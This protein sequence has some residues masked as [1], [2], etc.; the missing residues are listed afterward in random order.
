M[1]STVMTVPAN[2]VVDYN[3]T[4]SDLG[5]QKVAATFDLSSVGIDDNA[6]S[7]V[8]VDATN[9]HSAVSLSNFPA[10][11]TDSLGNDGALDAKYNASTN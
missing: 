8:I 5:N 9:S 1:G 6:S 3:S 10:V 2:G 11:T 4:T 7:V